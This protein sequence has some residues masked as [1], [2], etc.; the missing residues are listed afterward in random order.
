MHK[1][2]EREIKEKKQW[3]LEINSNKMRKTMGSDRN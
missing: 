2:H 3:K 1:K